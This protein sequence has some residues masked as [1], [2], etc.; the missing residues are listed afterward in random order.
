M[1]F[2]TRKKEGKQTQINVFERAP[3]GLTYV[4]TLHLP[5]VP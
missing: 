4:S 3:V 2:I 1:D 5:D